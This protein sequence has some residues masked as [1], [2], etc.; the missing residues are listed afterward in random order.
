ML[1]RYIFFVCFFL[2]TNTLFSSALIILW[3]MWHHIVWILILFELYVL[4]LFYNPLLLSTANSLCIKILLFLVHLLVHIYVLYGPKIILLQSLA[5]FYDLILL[6]YIFHSTRIFYSITLY[7]CFFNISFI[8][9]SA[10]IN[11][12]Y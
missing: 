2:Q 1:T 10:Y 11:H 8:Q 12:I 4:L 9:F 5:T 3:L 7:C 6:L